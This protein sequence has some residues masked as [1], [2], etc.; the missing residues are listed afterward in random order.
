MAG[1]ES[2]LQETRVFNPPESFVKQA[3]IAGMDAYR[4]LCAEAEHDYEGFWAR[5]AHEHLLWHKPFS[6]VLDES[7]APFYKWFEDGELNASYNCLERNLENGNA[8][9]VAIIFETDDGKVSRTTYRELHARVCRFANG[10]KALGIKKGDRVV[11]YM[12][13]SV[14]GI[15]A[16]QACARIGATHSVVFG[17]FS[18][19]SLQERIVDVGAVA[20]ITADEQMRGGKA[21]PL[22]AI[23]DEAL[24]MEGTD[25]VKHVIVY[26]RT[27]G[28]VNWVEGRDRAM[29]EVEAGQPDTCE[30]T[31]VS[32]EHPLF[33]LYTSGSTGKPKGVQHSTGGYLLWALLTMQ[34][35]FD[36]KPDDIFWCTADIGW[37]T[38]HSYIAYGPLAAGATQVVFEGVPT[39]PNAGRFWDM[40]Q[41]HKVNTFYTAP[42]AIRSLIKAAEAD[43]KVHPKQYDLSSLR[44]LGTVGEP[45]NPEAWMWY[46]TNIGGGRCPIVDTFWQTETGGHMMTPLPGATPL[47]P[48]SCTLPLP[49]IMAA[50][51]DETGHDVPNGQGGILVVKRPWPSMI[52]TI[53]GDPERFKKSYFPEEL[54]GKLYLAGDG[55]IR[56]KDTGYFTIMGRIDDVLNVSGHRMGTMEIESALVANPI[57]AEAAVVG[58]PDDMTGEAICAFVVL[59]RSRPDGDE[60]K[61]IANELRNWVGKEIGPIAKPKD[62]RFGDNLPKTRSGKIMRRLLRSLA[63][64]EDITQ[65]T[66]TLENPAILDQLKETR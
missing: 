8:D 44:L 2:V 37:V 49:G 35:T 55:S 47:V 14:E 62:I 23:A 22:K 64:G 10:L 12:P 4:A 66:S 17:G 25:A 63:K 13:M 7:N 21:L 43:E 61:Q 34:W 65:D 53:W 52:R 45:I 19:K 58:R 57:V 39:Y 5:L 38:G 36:L 11:I 24:A 41:R 48:G 50:V 54:G 28:N 6:K 20:L 3:N 27:N 30:V 46:H 59:K 16:M 32:A 42:T 26:R 9:K 56:D 60:A 51:V 40:I 15:V 1:I 29:D 31:P 18:A 33:I